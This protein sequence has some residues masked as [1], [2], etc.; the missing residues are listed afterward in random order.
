MSIQ[1]L[2]IF[3]LI[4]LII[5][6]LQKIEKQKI[7]IIYLSRQNFSLTQ[8]HYSKS[9]NKN[10]FE[11]IS[12]IEIE[13]VKIN[14][15]IAFLKNTSYIKIAPFDFAPKIINIQKNT[16]I[17]ILSKISISNEYW[18]EII[19]ADNNSS[20]NLKGWIKDQGIE[21]VYPKYQDLTK[22]N[23]INNDIF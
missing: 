12:N 9:L 5:Y 13:F 6:L 2:I 4:L 17:K 21:F 19:V 1:I 11:N 14:S 16:K 7:K 15:H 10:I 8:T 20:Y 22:S 18:Y 3:S 23:N